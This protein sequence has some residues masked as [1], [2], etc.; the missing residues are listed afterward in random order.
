M[1]VFCEYLLPCFRLVDGN[2]TE[3]FTKY[4]TVDNEIPERIAESF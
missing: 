1:N 3:K 4:S 2:A